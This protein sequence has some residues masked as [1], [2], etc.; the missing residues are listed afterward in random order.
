MGR[1]RVRAD[2]H[3]A[4]CSIHRTPGPGLR[5]VRVTTPSRGL[6]QRFAITR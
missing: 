5:F 6:V 4:A 3:L 1:G 2:G